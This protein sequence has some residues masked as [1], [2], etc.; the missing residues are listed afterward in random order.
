MKQLLVIVVLG[1]FITSCDL[2]SERW[3]GYVYP[4]KNNLS[5]FISAGNGFS[6]FEKCQ[7]ACI[8]II[9]S[10]N[11][12][13]ADYECGLNCKFKDGMNICEKTVK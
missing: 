8:S 11:W 9:R 7:A 10:N 1:L 2:I 3:D 13:N 4:N 12:Q 5:N 6:S